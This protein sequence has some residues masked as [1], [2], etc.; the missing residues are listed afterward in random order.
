MEKMIVCSD[1]KIKFEEL[2]R[3]FI[4]ARLRKEQCVKFSCKIM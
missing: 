3:A 1:G 4:H 2:D